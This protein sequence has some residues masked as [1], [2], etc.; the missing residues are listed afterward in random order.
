MN[1]QQNPKREGREGGG[2]RRRTFVHSRWNL[3]SCSLSSAPKACYCRGEPISGQWTAR[4][5]VPCLELLCILQY[6]KQERKVCVVCFADQF[7]ELHG[8]IT[9]LEK[10]EELVKVGGIHC[11]IWWWPC[12]W[13]SLVAPHRATIASKVSWESA[14]QKNEGKDI[15]SPFPYLLP[16]TPYPLPV[17]LPALLV[18]LEGSCLLQYFRQM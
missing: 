9:N 16:P 6:I 1:S 14:S 4:T 11:C 17:C 3:E 5:H 15:L 2:G 18:R 13:W 8:L 10:L 7:P 12:S